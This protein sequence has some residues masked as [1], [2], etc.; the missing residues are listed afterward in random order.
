MS[1]SAH[2]PV[3]RPL[4]TIRCVVDHVPL[5]V[6]V[7]LSLVAIGCII[8]VEPE[9]RDGGTPN[10]PPYIEDVIPALE[11]QQSL[12]ATD[13]PSFT[14][15]VADVNLEQNLEVRFC[16]RRNLEDE[17][18]IADNPYPLGPST[19]GKPERKPVATAGLA[20]CKPSDMFTAE[21]HYL[22]VVVT[23]GEFTDKFGCDVT[24]GSAS[25]KAFWSFTCQP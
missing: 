20:L 23:D 10:S 25:D 1:N 4:H 9:Y 7:V 13:R 8:P 3:A 6:G 21:T 12:R 17:Y 22:Y 19:D 11:V 16:Y 5:V 2:K 24:D 15:T 18:H 14:V